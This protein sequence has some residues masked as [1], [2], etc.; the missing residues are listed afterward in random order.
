[1]ET[2]FVNIISIPDWWMG[3]KGKQ[4]KTEIKG[5]YGIEWDDMSDV[6]KEMIYKKEVK[7]EGINK[8]KG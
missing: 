5:K 1:M 7:F 3:L 4:G 8:S 2:S 6:L